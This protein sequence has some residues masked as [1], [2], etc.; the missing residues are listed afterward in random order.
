MTAEKITEKIHVH[1]GAVL[2]GSGSIGDFLMFIYLSE[3]LM[4]SG[5]LERITM[6]VP[7]NARFLSGLLHEYP[8]I[9]LAEV[10]RFKGWGRFCTMLG[11][12]NLVILHP[13]LG[14][15][16][17]R[18]KILAWLLSRTE[19]SELIGFQDAGP[20]CSLYSK[21]LSYTTDK[22]YIDTVRDLARAAGSDADRQPPRLRFSPCPDVLETHG[23]LGKKY[24]VFHP[25]AS[26][27]RRM[28]T[29]DAGAEL[30]AFIR[31]EYP[32]MYVVLSGGADESECIRDIME[33]A[34]QERVVVAVGTSAKDLA[35]LIQGARLFIGTDTGITHLACFLGA[36]VLQAAHHG[37]AN[38]LTF[39]A[40]RA[41]VLYRLAN[42]EETHTGEEY[43]QKHAKGVLR[44]FG[45][46]PVIEVCRLLGNILRDGAV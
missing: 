32:E 13:T 43:L 11:R 16:P 6:L 22:P 23:L 28:F 46:V 31:K 41:T 33:K 45:A 20:L 4:R 38:W 10:S 30:V 34:G 1:K 29:I 2:F 37:T 39:Y 26:N 18:V 15:I 21:T 8:Y 27:P 7:R 24:V 25:G 36:K 17:L 9:S 5:S 35:S 40:Q 42:E 3:M 12:P 44:P 19:G 14:R